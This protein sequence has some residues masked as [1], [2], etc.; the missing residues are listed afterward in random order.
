MLAFSWST[1]CD[2][3]STLNPAMGQR[4]GCIFDMDG[5]YIKHGD[6]LNQCWFNVGQASTTLAQH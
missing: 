3:G 6:G 1:V 5:V 2:V 4:L